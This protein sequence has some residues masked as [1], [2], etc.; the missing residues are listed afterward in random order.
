[1][2]HLG[3]DVAKL[4]LDCA[5]RLETGKSRA[6]VVENTQAGFAKLEAWLRSHTDELPHVCMEATGIYWEAVAEFFCSQGLSG[7]CCKPSPDQSLFPG[8]AGAY[9]DRSGRC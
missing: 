5:L 6:K 3:I 2:L 8:T 7:Q 9:Q 1:M 4:K